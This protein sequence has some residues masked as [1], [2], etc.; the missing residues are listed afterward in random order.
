M[1][2]SQYVL[3]VIASVD[4]VIK[5]HDT[6]SISLIREASEKAPSKTEAHILDVI[7]GASTMYYKSKERTFGPL[8]IW[9]DG[10]RSFAPEDIKEDDLDILRNAIQLTGSTYLRT[11]FSHIVWSLTRDNSYGKIAVAGY[12]DEFQKQ[13]NPEHWV[14]CYDQIRSAYHISSM[15]GNKSDSFKQTRAAINEKL[16]QMNGSDTSF[17]S[18]KLLG[19]IVKDAPKEDLPKYD[20]II[21]ILAGKNLNPSNNNANLADTTFSVLEKLYS[22]LK[23]DAELKA[24]KGKYANYYEI[25]A[26]SLAQKNDYFRAVFM[27]KKACTLYAGINQEKL[28]ELRQL[29]E[30]WQKIAIKDM[31]FHKFEIDLKPTYDA[32]EQL[33]DGLSLSEAIVQFGRIVKIYHIEDVKKELLEKQE[34][35]VFTSL[36][37]SSLL[38]EQGQSVLELPSVRDSSDSENPDAIKKHMVRYV[39]EQR[40]LVDSLPVRIAFQLMQKFGPVTEDALDFLVRDNAIIPDKRAEIIQQGLCMALNGNLYAAMHLLL[41]QTENIFRNLVKICGDT[42]TFLKDDGSEEYKPLSSLF[43]SEK[44]LECYDENLIFTFQ[45]IMDDPAGENLRNLNGHGLLEPEVGNSVTSLYFVSLIIFLL[46]LYGAHA[47]PIRMDLA[48]REESRADK[49]DNQ[50]Q[51]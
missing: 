28:L 19:L 12:V 35:Y 34:K 10:S 36:F 48:K 5:D 49:P 17:L 9:K 1:D 51:S 27:L 32:V 16:M 21:S 22:R 25:Q 33:F 4:P 18:L 43:K 30:E 3:D 42:V 15:M 50:S 7:A 8:I 45:S 40:R 46:S 11:K 41:P 13:F 47:R 44:L 6:G 20:S 26:K 2:F 14:D 31:H 29:L 23:N 38:N 37:R 39:A 24:F